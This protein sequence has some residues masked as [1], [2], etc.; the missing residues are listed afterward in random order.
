MKKTL[1]LF[2]LLFTLASTALADEQKKITLNGDHP[3]ETIT[4]A[5]ANIFV[6]LAE[7]DGESG[8]VKI[9]IENL[10]ESNVLLLFDRAYDEKTIKK[11]PTSITF[12]KTFGGTKNKRVIEP[13]SGDG[14]RVILFRPSDK[15]D[16]P[17]LSVS[18]GSAQVCRLPI[19]IGKYKGK[20]MNK[21]LLLEKQII[22]LNIEAEFKPSAEYLGLKDKCDNLEREIS[23]AVLCTNP[24]HKPSLDRQRAGYVNKIDALKKDIDEAIARHN[25]TPSDNGYVRYTAL[26]KTLEGIDLDS[27][28]RD[29]GRHKA[30]SGGGGGG[31]KCSYC[32]L[33][34]Q[35]IYHKLDDLYKRIYSSSDRK[36]A[37]KAVMSQVNALYRCCT[38][39]SCSKHAAQ[40]KSGGDG[41]KSKITERYNRING[42]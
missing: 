2:V 37:K 5:Y 31:H 42:I 22:E 6:S 24:K 34:L 30:A 8:K 3:Q 18:N 7:N 19:Y 40:W 9:E 4:L 41:Y 39:A 20:K 32:S 36:A 25:W 16:L 12:D 11:M 14:D 26:K 23:R 21:V 38:D 27:R 10:D 17:L 33:S 29:C 15:Y 1:F 13:Y 28:E 35:Q